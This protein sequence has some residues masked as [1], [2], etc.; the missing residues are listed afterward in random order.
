MTRLDSAA[1]ASGPLSGVRVIDSTVNILG[2]LATQILGDMGADVIKIEAPEGDPMRYSG[3]SKNRAMASLFMNANRNKRSVV[4]DLKRPAGLKALQRLV[5]GADVFVHSLR[6]QSAERLGIAYGELGRLNPRLVYAYAPGYRPDGPNRNRPAFDDVIQ[7]ES[8]IAAMI[9]RVSGEPRYI[10]MV[11]ADKLCG[12]VLASAIGMAL[13]ERERTGLGQEVAVPMLET[14]LAFNLVEH[15][16]VNFFEEGDGEL[17]YSRMFSQH[18]RPYATRDGHICLLAVADEQWR[19]LFRVLGRA[20]LAA[21]ER[22]ATI[23]ARTQNIDALYAIVADEIAK[24]TTGAWQQALDEADVPNG[25]V[26]SLKGLAQN[27]YLKQTGFFRHY[28]HPSEGAMVTT[29]V[30]V[31]FARTPGA[32]RLAPPRLGEHTDSVLRELGYSGAEIEDAARG[33]R[34]AARSAANSGGEK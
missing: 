32:I 17:G 3:R 20:E 16:W 13:F 15:L 31:Q 30:P 23:G 2:P 28:E 29:A 11:M 5:E 8:G 9:G 19:R 4:L 14:V 24:K 33:G 12:T 1:A 10:P 26:Q 7:G 21:D 34:S 18:R 27:D 25:V 6:P 22:F